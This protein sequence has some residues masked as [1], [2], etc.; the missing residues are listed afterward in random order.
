MVFHFD[1]NKT[2]AAVPGPNSSTVIAQR[3]CFSM[4]YLEKGTCAQN[5]CCIG[6]SVH[7][8][9]VEMAADGNLMAPSY[10]LIGA[11]PFEVSWATTVRMNIRR[12]AL[13]GEKK[14]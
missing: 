2:E 4:A 5:L 13:R 12:N 7:L 8:A 9:Q 10:V 6:I 3:N 11:C 1:T 14:E